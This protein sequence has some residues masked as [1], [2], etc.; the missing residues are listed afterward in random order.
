VVERKS[1][2]GS[3]L[4]VGKKGTVTRRGEG[5]KTRVFSETEVGESLSR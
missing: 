4:V 3:R 5:E 2:T 1:Q